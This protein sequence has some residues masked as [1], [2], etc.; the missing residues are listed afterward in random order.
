M[1]TS[2]IST[3]APVRPVSGATPESVLF[4]AYYFPPHMEMGSRT[5]AQITRYLP[6]YGWNPMILTIESRLIEP[7]YLDRSGKS[8]ALE[9]AGR[10]IRT[11]VLP[12]A[13][14]LYRF[15]KRVASSLKGG[16]AESSSE[17]QRPASPGAAS[18]EGPKGGL[19]QWLLSVL[20]VPDMYTGWLVPAVRAGL[21]AIRRTQTKVIVSSAPCWTNHLVGYCL[22]KLTGL[23][24]VAHF[25]DPWV[26]G[27]LPG[28]FA[29]ELAFKLGRKFER[30]TV[31]HASRV[32]CVTEEHSAMFRAAYPHLPGDKFAAVPNGFDGAEWEDFDRQMAARALEERRR[33]DAFRIT[34]AGTLYLARNPLPVF[35]AL[36]R[37]IDAGEIP[38]DR[39]K[40]DLIGWCEVS[41]G[42]SVMDLIAEAGI[43]EC[44]NVVGPLSHKETLQRVAQSDLLLL[45]AEGW[46]IQVPGKTFEYLKAGRP[47]LALTTE[48]AV[49]SLIKRARG[50]WVVDPANDAAVMA[51]VRECYQEW[52]TNRNG[53]TPDPAV[54]ASY[55]RR[56]TTGQLGAILDQL[57]GS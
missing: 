40:I 44:V 32:V 35:R 31:T 30:L 22:S 1:K 37:L 53:R 7:E 48:G 5:C 11:G 56:V 47:I 34:Y 55:D 8:E 21:R 18:V 23:P 9:Q 39:V 19:R 24:W 15:G 50:G 28:A 57:V 29:S 12:H 16:S 17:S 27:H 14:D 41:E 46:T 36:R 26:T 4:I 49:A 45:L 52:A 13:L 25:R 42:R 2:T 54:V 43:Q 20:S 10:V 33:N 38:A 51:A 6:L 3:S